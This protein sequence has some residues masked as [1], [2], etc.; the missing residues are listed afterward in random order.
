[1]DSTTGLIEFGMR[2]YN[3]ELGRWTQQDPV[4]GSLGSPDRSRPDA[5]SN[6]LL[7]E[8]FAPSGRAVYSILPVRNALRKR[9]TYI[10][11][12]LISCHYFMFS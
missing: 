6:D 10:T 11:R 2:Y 1:M 3:P 7:D 9:L 12:R 8:G 5:S 4:A